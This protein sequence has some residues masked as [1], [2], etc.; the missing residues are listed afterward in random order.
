MVSGSPSRLAFLGVSVTAKLR[1]KLLTTSLKRQG[2]A[3]RFGGKEVCLLASV[4]AC[5]SSGLAL[6][7]T[8]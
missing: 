7:T 8:Q 3:H 1:K 4:F 6:N 5:L 2:S